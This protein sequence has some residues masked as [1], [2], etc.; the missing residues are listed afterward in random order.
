MPD[1]IGTSGTPPGLGE[2]AFFI[3]RDARGLFQRR[4]VEIARRSGIHAPQVIDAFAREIETAY[5]ELAASTKRD[6]FEQTS[7]LTASRISLVG[8][9]DLE[10]EIRIGD[11][12]NRLKGN[13]RIDRWRVQLRYMTLL[14]RPRMSA[15]NNPA[16]HA[17]PQTSAPVRQFDAAR[18][19]PAVA[20]DL[21]Q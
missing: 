10:L 19:G 3:L 4:L 16:E 9:D 21:R 17:R 20:R 14:D 8:H 11:L 5:D 18:E 12:I 2:D 7:G 6:G 1:P 13:E 15:E